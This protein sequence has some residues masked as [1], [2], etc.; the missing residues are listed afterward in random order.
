[1]I[2][3][4]PETAYETVHPAAVAGAPIGRARHARYSADNIRTGRPPYYGHERPGSKPCDTYLRFING[5][6]CFH[7]IDHLPGRKCLPGL[8]F[9]IL[10][11]EAVEALSLVILR[12]LFWALDRK[13]V[14]PRR[15]FHP[16]SAICPAEP[17]PP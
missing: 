13:A 8:P 10:G 7:R 14:L 12:L 5:M 4:F 3:I 1:M 6:P 11:L 17:Y 2:D 16:V 15:S 9:E